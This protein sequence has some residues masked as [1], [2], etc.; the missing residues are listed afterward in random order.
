[1]EY[2][3]S[4]SDSDDSIY[5]DYDWFDPVRAQEFIPPTHDILIH[6]HLS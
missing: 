5:F 1:M 4:D 2:C 6:H 3:S